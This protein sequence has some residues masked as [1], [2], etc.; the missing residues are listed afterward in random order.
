MLVDWRRQQKILLKALHSY[1]NSNNDLPLEL[2][3]SL[4]SDSLINGNAPATGFQ[5]SFG[6]RDPA[7]I[8]AGEQPDPDERHNMQYEIQKATI[9]VNKLSTRTY[10]VE[11]F[12]DLL[13][14]HQQNPNGQ[15]GSHSDA[16][17]LV[18]DRLDQAL[19]S[20]ASGPEDTAG[21]RQEMAREREAITKDLVGILSG[22][23]KIN[24]GPAAYSFVSPPFPPLRLSSH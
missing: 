4:S 3:P 2:T 22:I 12:L 6:D 7:M 10:V 15:S 13:H 11:K 16:L 1:R 23:D 21:I 19:K 5:P 9:Y 18:G 17:A 8:S 20:E 14:T 24:T